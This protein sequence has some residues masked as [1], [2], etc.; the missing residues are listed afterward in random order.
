MSV[1]WVVYVT[2]KLC[3]SDVS[4]PRSFSREDLVVRRGLSR[5]ECM[6][7]ITWCLRKQALF[8]KIENPN[9]SKL[10]LGSP[11]HQI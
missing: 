11:S 8:F 5:L 7:L 6:N 3:V 10:N 4:Y 9:Y 2:Y 1:I